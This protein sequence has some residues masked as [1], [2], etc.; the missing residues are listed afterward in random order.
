MRSIC[1]LLLVVL[2]AC[3][4]DDP[5]PPPADDRSASH[6]APDGAEQ[7]GAADPDDGRDPRARPEPQAAT[8]PAFQ[9]SD[10]ARARGIDGVNHCGVAEGKLYL[11]Q[12]MG[13]GA[14]L[15]DY[16]LDGDVDAY[17]VDGCTLVPPADGVVADWTAAGDGD[18]RLYENDGAGKFRDVSAE[19]GAG[20]TG[21]GQGIAVADY[22]NDGDPDF[23]LT[24]WGP[25]QLYRNGGPGV[26]GVRF[27]EIGSE[28]GVDDGHWGMGCAWFDADRDG[29]LDLYVTNYFAMAIER[30]PQCWDKIH[31]KYNTVEAACGPKGMVAEPDRFYENHGDG[32]FE[33]ASRAAGILAVEPRFG[34]GVAAFDSDVDGDT[35]V[36]VANDSRGNF[37]FEN[38]G[39][40][41]FDEVA[42]LMGCSLSR[43]GVPQAGM[44]IACGDYDGDQDPDLFVTNFAHDNNTLYASREHVGYLDVTRT[45]GFSEID[46]FSLGWGTEFLDLDN[47]GDLDLVICNGHVYPEADHAAP[48]L[49]FR[50]QNRVYEQRDGALVDVTDRSGTG[51]QRVASSRGMAAGDVDSDGDVDLLITELNEVPSLLINELDGDA[52]YLRV[53]L[54]GTTDNRDAIGAR[55]VLTAGGTSQVR[56][57]RSG[58]SYMS[59][60]D[61]R[62]LFGLGTS[63]QV[64]RLVVTWPDGSVQEFADLEVDRT[65]RIRQGQTSIE[66]VP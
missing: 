17:V 14:A 24:C 5:A 7:P 54:V 62:Q 36:F 48:E 16:D 21:F 61:P 60:H 43:S 49:Q 50:Q 66:D 41:T 10:Q 38:R 57:V 58:Q 23:L 9:F 13:N 31:C 6:A 37:L 22:D 46:Y 18:S 44:G 4:E 15:F 26:D 63:S 2:V 42:D 53:V 3:G 33:D 30:D 56:E 19:T 27:E 35:D 29:D 28:A 51:I 8:V 12:E 59:Y 39:D 32:T 65:I 52:H 55:L 25:N 20:F 47:D 11:L 34:L 40:G 45:V 1:G 64:E